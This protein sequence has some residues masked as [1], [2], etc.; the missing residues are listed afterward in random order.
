M[1]GNP[2][3]LNV[4]RLFTALLCLVFISIYITNIPIYYER[5]SSECITNECFGAP[6]PP[7]GVEG[8]QAIGLNENLYALFY[9]VLDSV[10]IISFLIAAII[11]FLK[12]GHGIMGLLGTLLLV[13]FGIPFPSLMSVAA[14]NNPLLMNI[15]NAMSYIG[16]TSLCVFFLLF[17]NGRFIPKWSVWTLIPIGIIFSLSLFENIPTWVT[18]ARLAVVFIFLLAVQI[19]RFRKISS[20]TERQQTKWVVYG[21]TVSLTGFLGLVFIPLLYNPNIFQEGSTLYFMIFNSFINLL[22]LIIPM[23]L[24]Y[25]LL[26]RRLWDI[27]PLLNRT[28]L[29]GVMSLCVVGIYIVVVWYLSNLFHTS[30]SMIISIVAT[31][32]VAVSF[33]PL[34]EKVQQLI[35]RKMYGVQENP[36]FVLALLGK[37]IQE[38][39]T[40]E[41]VLDQVVRTLIEALR[42]P[43]AAVK[44]IKNKDSVVL[45]ESGVSGGECEQLPISYR[46]EKLGYLVLAHR[47]PGEAFTKSDE[48]LWEILIQ[49]VGP[50]L[51]DLKATLDLKALNLD[52]QVSREKLVIAREEERHYLRRNLHDDLAPRLA[53]LAFTAAAAEDLVDK[54][55]TTVKSLLAEHQR[56]ILGT[57]DDIRRLVYDLR[58]PKID[59]LG[60]SEALK[61]RVD[62]IV[63]SIK[64]YN[65]D[66]IQNRIQVS[67]SAPKELP[68]IP[69]AVEVAI[70]RIL[71]EAVVNVVRHSKASTCK[72]ILSL[73]NN[74]LEIEILDDGIGIN[75][76]EK[77]PSIMGG[78][79]VSS[80]KERAAELG[81]HCLIEERSE[82]GT[83]VFA[84]VPINTSEMGKLNDENSSANSR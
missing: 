64:S 52:L 55:P 21:L 69:P 74:R 7:P 67:Y 25:A 63:S 59:E 24:T 38:S 54:E 13:S 3:G 9:T 32:I 50:L 11:I 29:Y 45:A 20:P 28:L 1:K 49:Q 40:P 83:R 82:G 73:T 10:F 44:I 53:A 71:S 65:E 31:S 80:M 2:I 46:G 19:Y 18:F 58:P 76:N 34:K 47:S 16:W 5:L 78:I 66:G 81:G 30:N 84:W 15:I 12:R 62:E 43:Y 23:T 36:F 33:S 39:K 27:D 22:M 35:V 48:K 17:P 72:I 70:Y 56:M 68:Q 37:K 51:Q 6:S 41:Q 8:L 79:G 77:A 61:Q 60:I 26:R 75:S 57:V 4:L 14:E 42:L